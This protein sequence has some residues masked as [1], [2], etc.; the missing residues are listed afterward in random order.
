MKRSV[1]LIDPIIEYSHEEGGL[2]VVGG[3]IYRGTA[4]PEM[5]GKYI[6]GNWSDDF[7]APLGSLYVATRPAS[8]HVW[9][10]SELRIANMPDGELG[11]YIMGFGQDMGG[12][13]YILTTDSV[14]PGAEQSGKLYKIVPAS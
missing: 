4:M 7:E 11:D 9:S 5:D 1:W 10:W 12:E 3:Y 8:G 6:F 14:G 13:V 2:V